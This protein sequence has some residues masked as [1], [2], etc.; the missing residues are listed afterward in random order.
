LVHNLSVCTQV[1]AVLYEEINSII[2]SQEN[3]IVNDSGNQ[4]QVVQLHIPK[5]GEKQYYISLCHG[6]HKG[7]ESGVSELCLPFL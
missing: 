7:F 1:P 6:P 2:F 3:Q 5:G 4:S